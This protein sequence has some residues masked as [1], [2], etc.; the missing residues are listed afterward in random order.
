MA[1]QFVYTAMDGQ[2]KEQRGR[3]EA[4]NEQDAAAKLRQQHLFTTSVKEVKSGGGGPSRA[5]GPAAGP[6]QQK[7]GGFSLFGGGRAIKKGTLTTMTR[8][9]A[10]LIAA[11]LPLVRALRTLERQAKNDPNLRRVLGE[12]AASV[13]GG[14]TFTEAVASHPKSFDKL[15]VSMVRAG[16]A[17]GSLEAVLSRLSE[18]MEQAQ[19]IAGKV[20]SAMIYPVVVLFVAMTITAGLMIFIVPKFEKIFKDML[21]AKAEL[22]A[23]TRMVMGI[24]MFMQNHYLLAIIVVVGTIVG[25]NLFRKTKVGVR[26]IDIV[27]I[28]MP[29]FNQLVVRATVAR[30]CR[31]LGT[32]MQSGVAVLQALQIVKDTAGN[33]VVSEAVQKVHDSV[34]E[35]ET[36]SKPLGACGVFPGMMVSMVEVGEETGALP[37]MLGRVADIYE[38]E[39]DRAVEGMTS[40]IEPVMI[41]FLA[42]IIGGIVIALFLPMIEIIKQ[43]GGGA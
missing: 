16:E 27:S 14:S 21:G 20:K 9:L 3:I 13:E 34:K 33:E 10:T 32:L 37:E 18:F 40:L 4:E 24:S 2:G 8:Q 22:P 29:P 15:Y 7:K 17:S 41:V 38:E 6:G 1:K 28:K 23:L 42:V 26:V 43:I 12:L 30:F 25:V 36:M 19:R 31:T 5:A 39:V 11:G 35:G